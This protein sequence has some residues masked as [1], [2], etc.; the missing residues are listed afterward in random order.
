LP[1]LKVTPF[2]KRLRLLQVEKWAHPLSIQKYNIKNATFRSFNLILTLK[3]GL[4]IK[5][6][7]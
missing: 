5:P 7:F 6:T 2:F 4:L 3:H 1:L